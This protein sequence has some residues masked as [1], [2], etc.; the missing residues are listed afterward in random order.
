MYPE[1]TEDRQ[2]SYPTPIRAI[3]IIWDNPFDFEEAEK[4]AKGVRQPIIDI[5][6]EASE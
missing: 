2:T 5:F 3:N 1:A 4:K 6:K